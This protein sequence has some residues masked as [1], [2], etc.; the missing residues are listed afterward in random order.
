MIRMLRALTLSGRPNKVPALL[1]LFE[2]STDE[3]RAV[4]FRFETPEGGDERG[5]GH[6]NYYHSQMFN[7][8]RPNKDNK[9][10]TNWCP[11]TTPAIPLDAQNP[12]QL[13][14]SMLCSLYNMDYIKRLA[15]STV[16]P[17][18]ISEAKQMQHQRKLVKPTKR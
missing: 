10:P 13:I 1:A 16:W 2:M 12:V 8:F 3:V 4:G 15:G 6:H 9:I 17:D 18:L 7:Y 5:H 14:I 11:D